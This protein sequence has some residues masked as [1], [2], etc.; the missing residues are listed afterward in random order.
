MTGT[1]NLGDWGDM[2]K[3]PIEYAILKV[4]MQGKPSAT[5]DG[6]CRYRG[7]NGT[8]CAVGM[9]IPD[10]LYDSHIEDKSAGPMLQYLQAKHPNNPYVGLLICMIH[11]LGDVQ[12]AHDRAEELAREDGKDFV[13][14]FMRKVSTIR[15]IPVSDMF[16]DFMHK[17]AEQ[18]GT[19]TL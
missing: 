5:P 2:T 9:L 13:E 19:K 10:D 11:A 17:V 3:H 14:E 12:Y 1:I 8:K 7:P 6:R 15:N 18:C 16:I 4:I